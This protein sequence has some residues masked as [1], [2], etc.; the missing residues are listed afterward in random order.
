MNLAL[1]RFYRLMNI[2]TKKRVVVLKKKKN[3]LDFTNQF[4]YVVIAYSYYSFKNNWFT[5][6]FQDQ[7]LRGGEK[8]WYDSLNKYLSF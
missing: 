6:I 5:H 2:K 4:H 7:M 3:Y 1:F 8:T